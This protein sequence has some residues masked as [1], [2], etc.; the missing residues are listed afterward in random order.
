MKASILKKSFL[1]NCSRGSTGL[2]HQ[3]LFSV[4]CGL[5]G[6]TR[7]APLCH[8]STVFCGGGDIWSHPG[9]AQPCEEQGSPEQPG[10]STGGRLSPRSCLPGRVSC[11]DRPGSGRVSCL[12][13]EGRRQV[14]LLTV[15]SGSHLGR[16]T[17]GLILGDP[18]IQG[19]GG[20][21][22]A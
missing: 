8:R 18:G 5:G 2:K 15:A 4:V 16:R 7:A 3:P 10:D 21:A 12:L 6:H 9:V 22:A 17:S 19:S 1:I 14:T 20:S 11:G 13:R